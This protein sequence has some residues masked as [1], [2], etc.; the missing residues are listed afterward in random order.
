MAFKRLFSSLAIVLV[1]L[2]FIP[3]NVGASSSSLKDSEVIEHNVK[4]A[5]VVVF[6]DGDTTRIIQSKDEMTAST[7]EFT[8]FEKMVN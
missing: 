7:N 1:F 4:S 6:N 8:I 3:L 2:T 5:N